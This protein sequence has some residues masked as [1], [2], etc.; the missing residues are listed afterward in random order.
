MTKLSRRSWLQKSLLASSTLLAGGNIS[1]WLDSSTNFLKADNPL[2]RLNWNENPYGPSF[3]AKEAIIKALENA[4]RYPDTKVGDLKAKI[5]EKHGINPGEIMITAG[6]TEILSLLGQHVGLLNGEILIPW[7]SFPTIVMFGQACGATVKKVALGTGHSIDLK[8]LKASITEN[9]TLIFVCNPNN[10]TSTELDANELR[11]FCKTV[12]SDILI[13]VDEAYIEYSKNGATSS[14]IKL[15]SEIS[16][17]IVC[18]T[19]S[20]AYGL[21]GLRIGYAVSATHNIEALRRRH[22]GWELS[23]GV[24]PLEG[25][26]A[27]LPDDSFIDFCVQKNNEGKE[28]M[29]HAFQ[30]WG[31]QYNPSSTNFIY[32]ESK[33][34]VPD[35]QAKLKEDNI[36]ITKWGDMT[37]HIRISIGKPDEMERLSTTMSKYL[38]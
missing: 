1:S 30:K 3:K 31:I 20:K 18:R 36:L 13:C 32:V 33:R 27:S 22:T 6:S 8:L 12:P 2:A 29:Y 26:L 15:V 28:I 21:A 38:A 9:T 11:A 16:N 19:F 7:P 25:A 37:H 24:A 34:F 35:I 23:A 14:M 5:S 4:N 10:P 17:L